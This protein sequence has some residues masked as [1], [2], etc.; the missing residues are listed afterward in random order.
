MKLLIWSIPGL[1][2]YDYGP[3]ENLVRYNS[4]EPPTF[5]I[6]KINVPS[7]LFYGL[8]DLLAEYTVRGNNETYF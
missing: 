3:K 2:D 1:R 7:Q 4:E 8:N 6:S 5:D